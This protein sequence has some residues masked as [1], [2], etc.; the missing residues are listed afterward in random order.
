[1]VTRSHLADK[2]EVD[3][4]MLCP[5]VLELDEVGREINCAD[6]V[7]VDKGGKRMH[8]SFLLETKEH[9]STQTYKYRYSV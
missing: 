8:N 2:V 5:L 9:Y 7:A 4:D 1:M 3:L 6:V